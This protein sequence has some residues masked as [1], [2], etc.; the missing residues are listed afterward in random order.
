MC[1]LHWLIATD[2]ITQQILLHFFV[3]GGGEYIVKWMVLIITLK[4]TMFPFVMGEL[5]FLL[6]RFVVLRIIVLMEKTRT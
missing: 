4:L 3:L 5:V 2:V 1:F 6:K